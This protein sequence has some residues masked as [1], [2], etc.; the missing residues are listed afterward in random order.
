PRAPCVACRG[1]LWQSVR[2][3]AGGV[4]PGVYFHPTEPGLMYIR[5]DV[6]GAYRWSA[7]TSLW[8]PLT[9]WLGGT[10]ADWSLMGI[11]SIAVDPADARRVY[12]AAGMYID[13]GSP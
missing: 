3:V 9:D 12:L 13:S 7:A 6:G 11:E 1:Y 2:I 8:T 10:S 4:M 5:A